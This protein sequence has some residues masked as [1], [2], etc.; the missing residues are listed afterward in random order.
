MQTHSN[1]VYRALEAMRREGEKM[2]QKPNE[3]QMRR[4]SS[5]RDNWSVL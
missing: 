3:E 5:I 1:S 4:K 2:L